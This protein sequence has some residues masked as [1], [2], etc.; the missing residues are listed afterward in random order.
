MAKIKRL[1]KDVIGQIAA[2]EVVERPMAAIKEMVENAIDA[3]AKAISVEIKGGGIDSIRVSDNGSGIAE[4]D[5]ALVF[6][7]HATSKLS[8]AQQL[9]HIN[10]LGFRGEALSS[11]AAVGRVTLSTRQEHMELGVE[12]KNE[13]GEILGIRPKAMAKGTTIL[14]E[15]LFFNAPV[16]RKFLKR[17]QSEAALVSDLMRQMIL[18][19]PEIAFSFKSDGKLIYRSS[20]DGKVQS[21]FLSVYGLAALR[22]TKEVSFTQQ[23]IIVEGLVGVGELSRGNRSHESFFI[24]NR[25]INSAI[26]SQAVEEG[27]RQRVMIGRYPTCCLYLQMPFHQ[28]DVNVHPNKWEV[29]FA[30]EKAVLDT[31]REAVERA[32]NEGAAEIVP[33]SF[34]PPEEVKEVK[35]AQAPVQIMEG[36]APKAVEASPKAELPIEK[37]QTTLFVS[38]P[39]K[40]PLA[41][42]EKPALP[43][44][45]E[46]RE[47]AGQKTPAIEITPAL[48]EKPIKFLGVA[49]HTYI[50]F[51]SGDLL[52]L[53]D[54]HALHER[55]LYDKLMEAHSHG[56][57]AQM[58]LVPRAVDLSLREYDLFLENQALLSSFGFDAEDFGNR[59]VRLH[60]VPIIL[61][62]PEAESA[63]KDALDEL[64]A[65]GSLSQDKKES[66]L[67]Q[68]ACKHAIK[69]GE[70]RS[71]DDVR[72][73]V[74]KMLNDNIV[75]TCPHGRPLMLK[76]SK[77]ELEKR[78]GRLGS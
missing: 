45:E 58:L 40:P 1:S 46:I 68:S 36:E 43:T 76:I 55:I 21:A 65:S 8:T 53:C 5:L 28:V 18:S 38:S 67:I 59:S 16:R 13:G 78:F 51:E 34:F 66:R 35:K 52:I 11:I 57:A 26:L 19:H 70:R 64:Q 9:S 24:N 7:R 2:G 41:T 73:L 48:A 30:N 61:G 6:E 71:M 63:F 47:L 72:A 31:V 62:E 20:G 44:M 50:L 54:Q 10:T 14:V 4:E 25:A 33:P 22:E 56:T 15:D 27:S 29:R 49:F 60:S 77:R 37:L 69:G 75:P 23:G 3:E 12:V 32:L 17:P 39:A 42:A 74:N